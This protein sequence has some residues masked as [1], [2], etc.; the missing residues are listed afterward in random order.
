MVIFHSYVSL[1]ECNL[2][3]WGTRA[4]LKALLNKSCFEVWKHTSTSYNV[5]SSRL[6]WLLISTDSDQTLK[7]QSTELRISD[8]ALSSPSMDRFREKLFLE[9]GG[10]RQFHRSSSIVSLQP[11]P[12]LPGHLVGGW[13]TPLKKMRSSDWII[14]PAIGENKKFMV[15][16]T[17]QLWY[18]VIH[19]QL[20]SG[21]LTQLWKITIFNGKT[22]YKWPCSIA[23]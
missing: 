16:T 7:P 20:P 15:Q 19:I 3:S 6:N 5:Q 14:L 21:K 10:L 17:N 22:H 13:P 18:P 2:C 1:P 12:D 9:L 8:A 11:I 4:P 23:I